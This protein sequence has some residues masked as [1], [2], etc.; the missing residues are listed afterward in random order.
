VKVN[1]TILFFIKIEVHTYVT[2]KNLDCFFLGLQTKW[3]K[4]I[5]SV[6]KKVTKNEF[7]HTLW[8]VV[9]GGM[10]DKFVFKTLK[11]LM[12]KIFG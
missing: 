3:L 5:F 2:R 4:N 7:F 12:K 8:Q 11:K 9:Q 1:F 6:K 10:C